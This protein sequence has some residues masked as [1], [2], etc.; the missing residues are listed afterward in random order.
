MKY[1]ANV[2]MPLKQRKQTKQYTNQLTFLIMYKS[3]VQSLQYFISNKFE[4]KRF[5]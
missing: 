5:Q 4:K 1:P 2:D 3:F